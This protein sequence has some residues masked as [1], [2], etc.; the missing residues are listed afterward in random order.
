MPEP[1]DS[2][3]I[4][5]RRDLP[6]D[7]PGRPSATQRPWRFPPSVRTS[8]AVTAGALGSLGVAPQHWPWAA[9]AI[10]GCHLTLA[11]AG[12]VP[13]SRLLGPNRTRL[14]SSVT[15]PPAISLTFDDGPDP[16]VTP[17]VLDLLDQAGVQA[18]FFLIGQ[19]AQAH[20][21]LVEEIGRRGHRVENHTYRHR[22]A[23]S[24]FGPWRMAR[25]IDRAQ[26]L[27]QELT[28]RRPR[29]FRPPAGFRNLFLEPLLGR[30][31]LYLATWT[32]RGFDTVTRDPLTV[33]ERLVKNLAAG[34][35]LLLHDGNGARTRTLT[36]GAGSPVVLE[37]LPRLLDRLSLQGLTSIALPDG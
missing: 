13:K 19:R 17:K 6:K 14:P 16:R 25:E 11:A 1:P 21:D 10:A 32:R 12:L 15:S 35:I 29:Y 9:T 30:R 2:S 24:A 33:T 20:R 4:A 5:D 18:S 36:G 31:G 23:F 28:G 27:L 34:D 7:T 22:Y 8:A 3:P 26:D 37:A